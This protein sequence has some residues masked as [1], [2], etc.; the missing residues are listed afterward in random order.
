MNYIPTSN[1]IAPKTP[2]ARLI[3][4]NNGPG[5]YDVP[6]ENIKINQSIIKIR[7]AIPNNA[8]PIII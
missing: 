6:V 4:F 5:V 8:P 3:L 2:N 1:N 7:N